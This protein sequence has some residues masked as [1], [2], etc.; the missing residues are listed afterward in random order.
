MSNNLPGQIMEYLH[1]L[2]A[3]VPG[4][5][6]KAHVIAQH[7]GADHRRV[8]AALIELQDSEDVLMRNGWYRL[9]ERARRA[10]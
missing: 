2:D 10:S 9:S 4:I 5:V 7:L 6:V 1:R 3:R 8:C